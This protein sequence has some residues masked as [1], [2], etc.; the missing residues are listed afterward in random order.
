VVNLG[1]GLPV[2]C[3][4]YL[5]PGIDVIVQAENG[6]LTYSAGI[7]PSPVMHPALKCSAA[8]RLRPDAGPSLPIGT[9]RKPGPGVP[10]D[11][12]HGPW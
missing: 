4:D 1:I 12:A 6:L 8:F 3:S 7:A 10:I 9:T 11:H 2:H 5:R